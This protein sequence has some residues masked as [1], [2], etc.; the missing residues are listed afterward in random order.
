MLE[1]RI[2]VIIC[3]RNRPREL[4]GCIRSLSEQSYKS[5]SVIV[6][7]QGDNDNIS[8]YEDFG[9]SEGDPIKIDYIRDSGTGLSRAR[10]IGIKQSDSMYMVFVDDDCVLDKNCLL[11]YSKN[12]KGY[13][14][15]AGR[16]LNFDGK[17]YN[18]NHGDKNVVLN[19]MFRVFFV[20]GG[21]FGLK[22]KICNKIGFFDTRLGAGE[23]YGAS[24]ETDYF[25]RAYLNRFKGLYNSKALCYHP[26]VK[27]DKDK[28]VSYG[29]GRGFFYR[30][31]IDVR[32]V[33]L[34]FV[35]VFF[36]LSRLLYATLLIKKTYFKI[37]YYILKAEIYCF[38][39]LRSELKHLNKTKMS[40]PASSGRKREEHNRVGI[41][42]SKS[43]NVNTGVGRYT[44]NLYKS[45][46]ENTRKNKYFLYS[47]S[48]IDKLERA[49]EEKVYTISKDISLRNGVLKI[50]W[51]QMALP[52]YSLSDRL[53]I[54]HYTDHALSLLQRT[55][56]VIIT[57]HDIAYV[58]FPW[59]FNKTRQIY[60]GYI[61]SRS[62]RKADIIIADSYSTKKDI[63]QYF[64]INDEKIKVVYLGVEN[65]FRP[66]SNVEEYRLKNNLPSKMILNVGTLEPRKNV[67]TLV[68]A[69]KQLKERGLNDYKLVI[70]G[71]KGWL[72]K[73]IFKEIQSSDLEKEVLFLGNIA[74]KD[75]PRLY[76]C[77]DVFAYPSLYE[78]FGL[79]PLEAM[80]CGVPVITSNTS[81]LP[82]VI[83]DAGIM[84]DPND[85]NSLC[86][87]I[88]KVLEDRELRHRMR[89]MGLERSKLFS[90]DK[91]AREIL[92]I[93]DEMLL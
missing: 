80:A 65:R 93:Y 46:L 29:Y 24:E 12:F 78:G 28:I 49:S 25:L 10:N 82:E 21:N 44:F 16:V 35:E 73:Q 88:C 31:N 90:W 89:D 39:T 45:I 42:V 27:F 53:D 83:G 64:G 41:N 51:E 30:K 34:L 6:V 19:N 11:E 7:D 38:V 22:K 47:S 91:A 40:Y 70:A 20:S 1:K 4:A 71:S 63:I 48:Q 66:I 69:F 26:R 13:D 59:L 79:P 57:V 81:S 84:I 77:A 55:R 8:S 23:K 92:E 56:P 50:L 68:K 86:E 76:N 43:I 3:T 61:G 15:I 67:V 87:G 17:R 32:K 60:K 18:R 58:R 75:L 72:Y 37:N 14:Y 52:F 36:R 62:I 85:V 2:N 33:L 5:F 74:D 9:L 54:F